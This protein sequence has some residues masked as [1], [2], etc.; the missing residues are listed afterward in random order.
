[1]GGIF[2]SR[3]DEMPQVLTA[4]QMIDAVK[5]FA[6]CE[7]CKYFTQDAVQTTCFNPANEEVKDS[8]GEEFSPPASFG[9]FNW[10][11]RE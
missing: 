4:S 3:K 8:N 2:V 10:E 5:Q 6:K 7:N 9:C 11:K 1:L